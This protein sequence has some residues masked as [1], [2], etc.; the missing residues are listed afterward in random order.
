MRTSGPSCTCCQYGGESAVKEAA[1]QPSW[2]L[3]SMMRTT[4]Y[5]KRSLRVWLNEPLRLTD[6]G[7]WHLLAYSHLAYSYFRSKRGVLPTLKEWYEGSEPEWVNQTTSRVN[8]IPTNV[9][10]ILW[11]V[12]IPRN[13]LWGVNLCT[14]PIKYTFYKGYIYIKKK[15]IQHHKTV[16]LGRTTNRFRVELAR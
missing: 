14:H 10:Q 3:I 9:G 12:Y 7:N 2:R 4:P 8:I 16:T 13:V 15:W 6:V 1:K 11:Q 5:P